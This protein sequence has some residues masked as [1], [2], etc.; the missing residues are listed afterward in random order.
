MQESASEK[1]LPELSLLN[2]KTKTNKKQFIYTT[3]S[4]LIAF[5]Y[6]TGKSMNNRLTYCGLVDARISASEKDLPV[7]PWIYLC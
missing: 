5:L 1:D 4:E 3:C 2:V 7:P 6:W